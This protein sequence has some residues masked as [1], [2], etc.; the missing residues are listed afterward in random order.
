MQLKND[1][2]KTSG[3]APIRAT[4]L[5]HYMFEYLINRIARPVLANSPYG[6]S[7][8]ATNRLGVEVVAHSF[9]AWAKRPSE[10]GA[11]PA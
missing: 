6:Y 4:P 1:M 5:H 10:P 8:S 7:P 3:A 2:Q 11:Y 9:H